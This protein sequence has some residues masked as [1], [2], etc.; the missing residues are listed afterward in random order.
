M[1]PAFSDVGML[2]T[3]SSQLI[4]SIIRLNSSDICQKAKAIVLLAVCIF[5]RSE[6]FWLPDKV[7]YEKGL[8]FT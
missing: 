1:Y 4:P 2:Q 8:C 3:N 6:L 7:W 5:W